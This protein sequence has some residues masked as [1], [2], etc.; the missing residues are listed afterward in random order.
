MTA[1]MA[2]HQRLNISLHPI[3]IEKLDRIKAI[4]NED[5]SGAVARL[6]VD[7]NEEELKK[8][9]PISEKHKKNKK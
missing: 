7:A 6:I 8:K 2:T 1:E 9:Y 5:T 3:E 4:L